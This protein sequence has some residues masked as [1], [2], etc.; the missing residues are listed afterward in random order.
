MALR[1]DPAE[2][3]GYLRFFYR[4]WRPTRLGRIWSRAFAWMAGLGLLP[5]LIVSLQVPDRATGKLTAH[6]LVA[7]TYNGAWY[8]VSML[9]AESNWVQDVRAAHGVAHIQRGALR[10]VRLTELAPAERAPILKAWCRIA[11]SGRRHLP[12]AYDAPVSRFE[13]IAADYPV[14][15]IDPLAHERRNPAERYDRPA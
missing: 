4:G 9:G 7:A 8:L 6:V 1:D 13:G 3:H 14:F 5:E 12:V 2:Q 10:S 11:R 15:R